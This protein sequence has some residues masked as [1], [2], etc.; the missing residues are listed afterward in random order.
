MAL[1]NE[2]LVGSY[3]RALQKLTGIKGGVPSPQLASEIIPVLPIK[4]GVENDYLFSWEN[5]SLVTSIGPSVGNASGIRIR[6]PVGSNIIAVLKKVVMLT[7]VADNVIIVSY[8]L[9]SAG[10]MLSAVSPGRALDTRVRPSSTCIVSADAPPAVPANTNIMAFAL[11][12]ATD[13][14]LI[15]ADC[16]QLPLLPGSH[17]QVTTN[18]VN[19]ILRVTFYWKERFLEESERT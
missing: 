9:V 8:A 15:N 14:D 1:F 12:A 6:N 3:N 10:D 18:T 16:H 13:R 19:T 4:S 7:T 11:L 5:Y 2:I 17:Y